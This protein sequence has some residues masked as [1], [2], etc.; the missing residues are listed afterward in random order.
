MD[1]TPEIDD[2]AARLS[3]ARIAEANAKDERIAAEE[4]IIAQ[5]DLGDSERK[6]ITTGNGLKLTIQSG[7]TYS[8]EKGA[9]ESLLPLTEKVTKAL[10][11]KEYERWRDSE[12]DKF[13]KAC[14]FVSVKPKK[15]SVSVSIK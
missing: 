15:T 3:Q 10:D 14:Q 12:P 2:L 13:A 5:L 1:S 9:D 7:M 11:V 4:A 6:T 8:V